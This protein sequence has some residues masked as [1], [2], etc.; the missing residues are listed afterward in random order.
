MNVVRLS[1][2]VARNNLLTR[3]CVVRPGNAAGSCL[4]VLTT[5]AARTCRAT[6]SRTRC[7]ARI[8]VPCPAPA[9]A[10]R[11]SEFGSPPA[12]AST[13]ALTAISSCK[14]PY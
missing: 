3:K 8:D 9:H 1:E 6:L 11:T 4:F 13:D 5:F 12:F 10:D 14:A 7:E 2:D